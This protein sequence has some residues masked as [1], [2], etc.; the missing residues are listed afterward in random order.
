MIHLQVDQDTKEYELYENADYQSFWKGIQQKKLDELEQIL[1]RRMLHLP[2]RRIIDIGCGYGRLLDCY[3]KESN[4]VVLLDS[5]VSLLQKAYQQSEGRAICL[6]CDLNHIPFKDFTFDQVLMIRVFHH[7]P[8]SSA[9]LRELNRILTGGGHLLFSYCNKKNLERI[10]RWVIGK[11]PYNPFSKETNW[12]W[13]VFFMHHPEFIH[14]LL[15]GT[16]F[17]HI[18]ENG[19]GIVDKIAGKLGRSGANFP[20]GVALAPLSARFAWA[21]WIFCDAAK[22]G[23]PDGFVDAPIEELM[24]CLNCRSGLSG[25]TDGFRCVSCGQFYPI[26]EGVIHFLNPDQGQGI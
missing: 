14:S 11:N 15:L 8:D 21:P 12:V 23:E 3:Q 9:C 10:A 2:A 13:N 18:I 24:L 6:R 5:S 17:E 25:S 20:P 26:K 22:T 16:G 4:Q 7:L 19:A 1:I